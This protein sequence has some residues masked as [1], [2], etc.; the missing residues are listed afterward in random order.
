VGKVDVIVDLPTPIVLALGAKLREQ[1][2]L[3]ITAGA[4]HLTGPK[5]NAN[6]VRWLIGTPGEARLPHVPAF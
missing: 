6:T 4:A 1:T 3:F 5:C 2:K